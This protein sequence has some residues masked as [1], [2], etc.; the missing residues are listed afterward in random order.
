[1]GTAHFRS[2]G[3]WTSKNHTKT[4]WV[5]KC[6]IQK[7]FASIDQKI[8]IEIIDG[9][10]PDKD[11]VRLIARIVS[12]F[13]SARLGV[14]LPLGNLTSQLFVNIYMNEFDQFE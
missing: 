11:I 4:V 2:L 14:G 3:R 7:F 9:Y 1:M 12:S 8:L 10:M 13:Y 5:L 6:D